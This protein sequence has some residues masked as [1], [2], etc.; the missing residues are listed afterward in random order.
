MCE[1]MV[2]EHS[3]V[4]RS[5]T[6][7]WSDGTQGKQELGW[8]FGPFTKRIGLTTGDYVLAIYDLTTLNYL[9]GMI[10][11]ITDD[12]ATVKFCDGSVYVDFL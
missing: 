10:M 4:S 9:P 8:M 11:D 2:K 1:G 5:F 3:A 7:Q 6:I 12:T